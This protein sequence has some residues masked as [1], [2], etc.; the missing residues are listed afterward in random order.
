MR[1]L[2]SLRSL[3]LF[4]SLLHTA[5]S[6][7][8]G[9]DALLMSQIGTVGTVPLGRLVSKTAIVAVSVRYQTWRNCGSPSTTVIFTFRATSGPLMALFESVIVAKP[10]CWARFRVAKDFIVLGV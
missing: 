5:S 4:R 2:E 1:S 8:H 6:R 3:S 10:A 9:S 7:G